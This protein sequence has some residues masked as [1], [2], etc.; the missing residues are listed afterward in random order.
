MIQYVAIGDSLTVG[1]GS[2]RNRNGDYLGF[3]RPYSQFVAETLNRPVQICM[4]AKTGSTTQQLF[5]MINCNK[6]YEKQIYQADIITITAGSRDFLDAFEKAQIFGSLAPLQSVSQQVFHCLQAI[7]STITK[8]KKMCPKPYMIRIFNLYNPYE[9]VAIFDSIIQKFNKSLYA[10]ELNKQVQIV[11]TYS[12][13]KSYLHNYLS[14]DGQHP[15]DCGYQAMAEA[16]FLTGFSP[17]L[18]SK[19]S[20]KYFIK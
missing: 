9:N 3:V 7:I 16:L 5:K 17:F 4:I 18:P 13:F 1:I 8:I 11:D 20:Y 10:L 12:L 19:C 14:C 6:M 2:S 15:N